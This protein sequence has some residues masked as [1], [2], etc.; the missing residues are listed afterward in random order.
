VDAL[1][2]TFLAAALAEW[3]DKTQLLAVALAARFA[4]PRAVLAG[5]AL[6]A[7]ANAAIAAVGGALLV[8]YI[9][10]RAM[11]LLVAL[12]LLFAGVGGLLRAKTPQTGA[13]WDRGAFFTAAGAFFL[14]EF[15]DKTQFLTAA[16]AARFNA[17]LLATLGATAGVMAACAPAVIVG[18]GLAR[19]VPIRAVRVGVAILFLIAGF[20]VAVNALEL[21]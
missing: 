6:A 9:T 17:P 14:T 7:L 18:E 16:L 5:I 15:G 2:T 12:A 20:I 21:V 19:A 13:K 11:S 8:G 3:G 10:L 4:N 1:L